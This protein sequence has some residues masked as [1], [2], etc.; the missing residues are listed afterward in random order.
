MGGHLWWRRQN[1]QPAFEG[2]QRTS[3]VAPSPPSRPG[4]AARSI[5]SC[6]RS[7]LSAHAPV[8]PATTCVRDASVRTQRDLAWTTGADWT[9]PCAIGYPPSNIRDAFRP[10]FHGGRARGLVVTDPPELGRTCRHVR[11]RLRRLI[12][13]LGVAAILPFAAWMAPRAP[14]ASV[15]R[16]RCRPTIGARRTS[17]PPSR[18]LYG[19]QTFGQQVAKCARVARGRKRGGRGPPVRAARWSG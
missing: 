4:W 11:A 13:S 3:S 7:G 6:W 12:W 5:P 10:P 1:A 9:P 17:Q 15:D 16:P 8:T 2:F 18:G 19:L 14:L